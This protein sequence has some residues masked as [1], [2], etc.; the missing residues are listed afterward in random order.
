MGLHINYKT[1]VSFLHKYKKRDPKVSFENIQFLVESTNCRCGK[2]NRS[3]F[4][5]SKIQWEIV[6]VSLVHDFHTQTSTVQ[7]VC[8]SVEDTTLTVDDGL[9]E[10]ETVQ[11]EC[12]GANTKCSKPDS[13]DRPCCE[14]EVKR[15]G[16]VE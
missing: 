1:F 6:C 14:E 2:C 3:R 10:V 7:N 13:Y 8:P 4:S 15:T 16:I 12:H 9:V 11:V 5:S